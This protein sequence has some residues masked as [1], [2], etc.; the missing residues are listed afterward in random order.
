MALVDD[1]ENAIR[2]GDT[3][4]ANY[5]AQML[6]TQAGININT[7]SVSAAPASLLPTLGTQSA[8]AA[9]SGGGFFSG[10]LSGAQS[11]QDWLEKIDPTSNTNMGGKG[12]TGQTNPAT[13]GQATGQA[14]ASAFSFITD[15]P[16][17]TTTIL[18]LI[19]IIA[20]IFALA[21]GSAAKVIVNTVHANAT[22]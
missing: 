2:S 20:G 21:S 11:L 9:S 13:V 15:I 1:Y 14:T 4:T 10:L 16:R 7:N 6:A 17:V 5:L 18:G 3:N 12:L 19:L 22:S 8:P